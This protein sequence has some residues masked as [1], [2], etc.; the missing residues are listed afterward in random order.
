MKK[1][2]FIFFALFVCLGLSACQA[3]T[4]LNHDEIMEGNLSSVSG[5]YINSEGKVI[6]LESNMTDRLISDVKYIDNSYYYLNVTTDDG[7]FGVGLTIYPIGVEVMTWSK[8]DG[9]IVM[10]TDT[11]K[12]RI[13]Y[14]HDVPLNENEIYEKK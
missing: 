9:E 13:Y 10:E 8:T 14:G 4:R 12:I 7:M 3:G 2:V 5:E 6:I 11:T 1:I